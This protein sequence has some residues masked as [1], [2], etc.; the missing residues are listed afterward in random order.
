MI[1]KET[2]AKISR[3]P[4]FKA[5][6]KI[7]D[8]MAPKHDFSI[9]RSQSRQYPSVLYRGPGKWTTICEGSFLDIRATLAQHFERLPD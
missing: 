1:N 7:L 8:Q 3:A 4:N 6:H 2:A 9:Y 5:L